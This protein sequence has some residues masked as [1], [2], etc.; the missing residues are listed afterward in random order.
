MDN[1]AI[2]IGLPNYLAIYCPTI[3]LFL[4]W[5]RWC[6]STN[7]VFYWRVSLYSRTI[8]QYHLICPTPPPP[9]N[10]ALAQ[11]RH[12]YFTQLIPLIQA[13]PRVLV[14]GDFNSSPF[15]PLFRQFLQHSQLKQHASLYQATWQPLM[16]NIDHILSK[17]RNIHSHTLPFHASDHR[18]LVANW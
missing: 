10:A 5:Q 2:G 16:L 15:S 11:A 8:W 3:L 12:D 14:V 9:I 17:N 18:A 7:G 13:N 6:A 1:W 4:F